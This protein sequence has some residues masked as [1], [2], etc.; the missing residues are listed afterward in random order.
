[1]DLGTYSFNTFNLTLMNTA[2]RSIS[3]KQAELTDT[4]KTLN[5]RL[6]NAESQPHDILSENLTLTGP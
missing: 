3:W 4:L 1:M 6:M 5:A 2:V